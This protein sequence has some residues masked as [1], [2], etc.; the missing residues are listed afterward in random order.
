MRTTSQLLRSAAPVLALV[1]A[2]AT[3]L[4]A[5][6]TTVQEPDLAIVGWTI[7]D[8]VAG[9]ADGGLHPGET[10]LLRIYLSNRGNETARNVS[11]LI[12]E[13]EDHPD[14][15]ILDKSALWPDLP[16][17]GAPGVTIAPH[18]KI[19]VATTR[20][21]RF[22]IRLRLELSAA[23]GYQETREI[24]LELVDP[25]E[26]D[27]AT[28]AARPFYYGRDPG[29]MLGHS[30]MATGD[31]DGD[32]YDDLVLGVEEADG[33]N[34]ARNLA[35]EVIVVFG[36]P[37]P[38]VDTDLASV[39]PGVSVIYGVAAG[40]RL[41]SGVATGDLNGDG[42]DELLLGA[43]GGDGYSNNRPEAGDVY[44]LYGQAAGL[45]LTVDLFQ[46]PLIMRTVGGVDAGDTLG[47]SV[48]AGD[49]N[50]DGY[51]DLVIGARLA[52]GPGNARSEAG[53][54][55]VV[56]GQ[57]SMLPDIDLA[58]LPGGATVIHGADA[59]DFLG[60]DVSSGDLDGDGHDDVL[61]GAR[62]AD[63]PWNASAA[64]GEV[65]VVY[66]GPGTLANIDLASPPPGVAVVYG[67]DA[68][69]G[70]AETILSADLNGDGRRPR[71]RD[72]RRR[73]SAKRNADLRGR[74]PRR[75]RRPRAVVGDRP[76]GA[77][78]ERERH[79]GHTRGRSGG[80]RS[81]GRPGR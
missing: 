31:F 48:A 11:A 21:C 24:T 15:E 46:Q 4:L 73:R 29:D 81:G 1:A 35:G 70:L 49:V 72:R 60:G 64:A 69:D 43:A 8:S 57:S 27:L 74:V 38:A 23:D 10:A 44:V 14:V 54:V 78:S 39:T 26:I 13:V 37:G 47:S 32:G 63:G 25:Q 7:D 51:D 55:H 59:G 18:F 62:G 41:G 19:H 34:N 65:A 3:S 76:R 42:Y 20:P 33:P 68:A 77:A 80:R 6:E 40:D 9:N 71:R 36:G 28:G 61:A 45:A 58:A 22:E 17:T 16:A 5:E 53:A 75:V 52:D 67:S 56:Y 30:P 50:A 66:G 2:C 12:S 79:L